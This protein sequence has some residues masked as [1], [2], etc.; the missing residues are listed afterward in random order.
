MNL[1]PDI[2]LIGSILLFVLVEVIALSMFVA[3]FKL[4]RKYQVLDSDFNK[5]KHEGNQKSEEL[6]QSAQD[7]Y[8]SKIL[9]ASQKAEEIISQSTQ[10]GSEFKSKFE[11]SLTRLSSQ[12][13][14]VFQQMSETSRKEI[15]QA[16]KS[17]A[18]EMQEQALQDVKQATASL[19]GE[20]KK[21]QVSLTESVQEAYE[22]VET[23]V[24]TYKTAKLKA[25]D[26]A[27]VGVVMNVAQEVL[28][29]TLSAQDHE[30]MI[31]GALQEAKR[32][33]II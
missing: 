1:P 8:Q 12:Q 4:L 28:G 13:A 27:V 15:S 32:D 26:E 3:Y 5:I 2:M 25:I 14:Q 21:L 7:H 19:E 22:K 33:K 20:V 11:A 10:M 30:A 17:V 24:A 6:L 16:V 23:E 29:K 18:Q 9:E 31:M